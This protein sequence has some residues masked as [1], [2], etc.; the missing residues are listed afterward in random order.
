MENLG[1]GH[2]SPIKMRCGKESAHTAQVE[3]S[4]FAGSFHKNN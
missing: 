4:A 3:E 2:F 1:S